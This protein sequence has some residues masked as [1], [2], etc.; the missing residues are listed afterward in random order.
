MRWV[1]SRRRRARRAA[2]SRRVAGARQ[3]ERGCRRTPRARRASP[4][5]GDRGRTRAGGDQVVAIR[6]G[7]E[8][9][10]DVAGL[11]SPATRAPP[12]GSFDQYRTPHDLRRAAGSCK[13]AATAA[14]GARKVIGRFFA[15][16]R[17]AWSPPSSRGSRSRASSPRRRCAARGARSRRRAAAAS[18]SAR[19]APRDRTSCRARRSGSRAARARAPTARCAPVASATST[20]TAATTLANEHP[21]RI[22]HRE[23]RHQAEHHRRGRERCGGAAGA[24]PRDPT[25]R[26]NWMITCAMAPAPRP[27]HR[28]AATGE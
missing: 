2:R 25:C 28:T 15:R 27:R 14:A 10:A 19:A 8:Q 11:R 3:V 5:S 12:A 20:S 26:D 7:V 1:M 21:R 22:H 17:S 18:D 13:S 9:A 16:P 4:S 24:G 6:D 23:A